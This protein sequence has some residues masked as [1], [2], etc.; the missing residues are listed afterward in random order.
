MFDLVDSAGEACRDAEAEVVARVLA[1]E[2]WW[3]AGGPEG[4][5]GVGSVEGRLR[6]QAAA[7]EALTRRAQ[8]RSLRAVAG[9][10][11]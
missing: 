11:E 1:A 10:T 8:A 7:G 4:S 2:S 6:A 5:C 3:R 9:L